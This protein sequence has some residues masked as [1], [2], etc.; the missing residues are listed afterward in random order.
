MTDLERVQQLIQRAGNPYRA[1]QVFNAEME[2]RGYE[3]RMDTS[4]TM[5]RISRGEARPAMIAFAC[6]ILEGVGST[7]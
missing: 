5:Q 2:R 7:V 1:A 3:Y 4:S 6:T